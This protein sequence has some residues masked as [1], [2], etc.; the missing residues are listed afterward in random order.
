MTSV[1]TANILLAAPVFAA[2]I[3]LAIWGI[4]G[5]RVESELR[6]AT[7]RDRALRHRQT[8]PGTDRRSAGHTLA[9]VP[10][11]AS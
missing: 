11:F 6:V 3:A 10:P 8:A 9:P 5:S 1:L 4:R 2:I 7:V